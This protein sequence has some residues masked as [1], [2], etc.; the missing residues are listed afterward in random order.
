[1]TYG[2][3]ISS[4]QG[5]IDL[6]KHSP[7]FVIIRAGCGRS[8]DG[9]AQRNMDE[10]ERLGIPYGVY[11]YSYALSVEDAKAEAKKCLEVIKGRTI[12]VGVWFDMEDADGYKA[13]NGALRRDLTSNM[14]YAFAEIIEDA[15]YYSGIYTSLSWLKDGYISGCERFDK[16][17]ACWGMNNGTLNSK[18]E[19]YGTMQ[20]YAGDKPVKGDKIDL[21]VSYVDLSHY[22]N[23]G[24]QIPEPPKVSYWPPRTICKGMDGPD[25]SALQA[26]LLA[27]GYTVRTISGVFDE[28]T[29]ISARKYQTDHS[30]DVDGIVGPKTWASLLS[31]A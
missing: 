12:S 31:M 9:K 1:M 14:C 20:Q 10:C 16:W 21:D 6:V 15:G 3:D 4:W 28:A 18:T 22:A 2:I 17:V 8:E 30:L 11:W 7:G 25:V 27:H 23:P 29:E 24:Q 13:R 5:D 26:L 19:K